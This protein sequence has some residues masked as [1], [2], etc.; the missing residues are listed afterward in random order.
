MQQQGVPSKARAGSVAPY[1]PLMSVVQLSPKRSVM[2]ATT[3][4]STAGTY[5][6]ATLVFSNPALGPPKHQID[7]AALAVSDLALLLAML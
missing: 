5:L 4:S 1:G 7:P 3:D 6:P 2:M